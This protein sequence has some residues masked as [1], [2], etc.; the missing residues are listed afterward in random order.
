MVATPRSP[1]GRAVRRTVI[2]RPVVLLSVDGVAR[3]EPAEM[4]DGRAR[5]PWAH[6]TY[7]APWVL[8]GLGD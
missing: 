5:A 4:A 6:P 7:W 8:W 2:L 1:Q 3:A